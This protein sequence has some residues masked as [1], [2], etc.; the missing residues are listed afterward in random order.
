G[1]RDDLDGDG[2]RARVLVGHGAVQGAAGRDGRLVQRQRRRD[3]QSAAGGDRPGEGSRRRHVARLVR[4][5][6]RERVAANREG[7]VALRAGARGGRAG[8]E[9][10]AEGR[11][12]LVRGEGEARGGQGGRIG[13][14]SG[15]GRGRRGQVDRPGKGRRTR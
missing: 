9:L 8:V 12:R 11:T 7:R 2:A 5:R 13:G 1:D 4:R 10:A 15:D 14:R 3:D 6:H